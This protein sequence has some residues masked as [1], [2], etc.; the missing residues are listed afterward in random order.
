MQDEVFNEIEKALN[1][2]SKLVI[3]TVAA[4]RLTRRA[5]PKAQP[6]P[7]PPD[8]RTVSVAG[9]PNA[10]VMRMFK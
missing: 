6:L 4:T 5:F 1:G 8:T 3:A 7:K 2:G 10:T 9:H